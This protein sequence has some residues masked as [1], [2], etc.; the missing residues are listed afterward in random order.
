M[1]KVYS[2]W[3]YLFT[4]SDSLSRNYPLQWHYHNGGLPLGT[5]GER[6]SEMWMPSISFRSSVEHCHLQ[7]F[8][9]KCCFSPASHLQ[10]RTRNHWS[11]K[12]KC[13]K[14]ALVD[15]SDKLCYFTNCPISWLTN[16]NI[17]LN[18]LLVVIRVGSSLISWSYKAHRV[19]FCCNIIVCSHSLLCCRPESFADPH[20]KFAHFPWMRL[21]GPLHIFLCRCYWQ[22]LI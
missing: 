19:S 8:K 17:I 21:A 15:Q 13:Q 9:P 5:T 3:W 20:E 4:G 14:L 6:C 11:W 22:V 12:C 2:V 7:E 16:K 10:S 18:Q 1:K